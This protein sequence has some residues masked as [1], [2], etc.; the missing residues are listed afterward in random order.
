MRTLRPY[1]KEAIE[2]FFASL[3][4]DEG[5]GVIQ[6]PTGSGKSI[7]IA[8]IVESFAKNNRR[9]L[10]LCHQAEILLQNFQAAKTLNKSV[11]CT[12][13]GMKED[14]AFVVFASRDSYSRKHSFAPFDLIIIDEAHLVSPDEESSY[15][16]IVART[17]PKYVLGLTATPYRL[18]NG[19][20][21]GDN[22]IFNKLLYTI[23]MTKLMEEGHLAP[24]IWPENVKL[25]ESEKI[26]KVAGDYKLDE[27]AKLYTERIVDTAIKAWC[28]VA[29][30]RRLSL[31]FCCSVEHAKLVQ[32]RLPNSEL[33][34][35]ETPS[36]KREEIICK[37]KYGELKALVNVGVLTTGIDIPIID[38]IVFMRA[39]TSASL[40]VQCL[41]RGL[42]PYQDKSNC[43]ILDF[44]GNYETFGHPDTPFIKRKSNRKM[45]EHDFETMLIGLLG[46][47]RVNAGRLKKCPVCEFQVPNATK[48][49][50]NCDH[51]FV[52]HIDNFYTG[53]SD[54]ANVQNIEFID[55]VTKKGEPCKIVTY[56]TDRGKIR[57][58]LLLKYPWQIAR[59]RERMYQL[60]QPIARILIKKNLSDYW[61][62]KKVE[63]HSMMKL[64]SSGQS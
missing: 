56:H 27:Q 63:T 51:I 29:H 26:K 42:R 9:V 19:F 22:N 18:D 49:C 23:P 52:N 64:S 50:L 55:S 25:V 2:K 13:L 3:T 21:Y 54:W 24:F 12:G 53:E 14:D 46:E 57:E 38:C 6:V 28:A 4:N 47:N 44:A 5:S 31:F 20:I 48:K 39:T 8:E 40:F 62:V 30:D 33:I 35:G 11:F 34:T 7:I 61:E 1:Q 60:K 58:W 37:A 10:V 17:H 15:Q 41:G 36:H 45:N 43:L 32:S 16:R 59:T